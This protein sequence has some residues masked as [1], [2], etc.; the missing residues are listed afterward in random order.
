MCNVYEDTLAT[1]VRYFH[2]FFLFILRGLFHSF[3]LLPPSIFQFFL[4]LWV[5]KKTEGSHIKN[6]STWFEYF[7]TLTTLYGAIDSGLPQF[8]HHPLV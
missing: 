1:F 2:F 7:E 5:G 6:D 3:P 8:F 4:N